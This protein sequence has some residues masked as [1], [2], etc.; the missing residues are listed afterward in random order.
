MSDRITALQS[1][2]DA[3]PGNCFVRYGL[4]QEHAKAGADQEAVAEFRRIVEV[5]PS[6]QAAYYHG[7]KALQR[8]GDADAA[9]SM[10]EK[11][12]QVAQQ[13]GDAHALSELE[14]ALAELSGA[15]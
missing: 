12:S 6:Y 7:G 3:D 9:R 15:S 1:M 8:L 5:D 11:G 13:S 10:Y 14:A 2:L 4:A